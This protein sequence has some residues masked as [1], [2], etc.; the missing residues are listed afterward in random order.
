MSEPE[1]RIALL[2]DADNDQGDAYAL[3]GQSTGGPE[4]GKT[5][6]D[7]NQ[8]GNAL[9]THRLTPVGAWGKRLASSHGRR[10]SRQRPRGSAILGFRQPP[11]RN[12]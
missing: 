10:L 12:P 1:K 7:N 9:A 11:A 6:A 8:V 3:A 2:I 5:A 4:T